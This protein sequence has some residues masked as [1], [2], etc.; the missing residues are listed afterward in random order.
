MYSIRYSAEAFE[1]FATSLIPD[2]TFSMLVLKSVPYCSPI[3]YISVS[4]PTSLIAFSGLPPKSSPREILILFA[5]STKS[6]M[7]FLPFRPNRPASSASKSNSAR[8]VRVFRFRKSTY[9]S[10]T[11]F[12]VNSVVFCTLASASS[13]PTIPLMN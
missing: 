9:I 2:P 4:L 1:L 11:S 13:R 6:I 7:S 3:L 10:L 8:G 12:L 5:T